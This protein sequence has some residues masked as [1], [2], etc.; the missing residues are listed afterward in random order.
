MKYM[1]SAYIFAC[2]FLFGI[3]SSQKIN[4]YSQIDSINQ[5]KRDSVAIDLDSL[6]NPNFEKLTT[7]F[8]D[9]IIVQNNIIL[10]S[11]P[12]DIPITPFNIIKNDEKNWFYFGQN[13]LVF[14]QA[15]FSNWISGGNNNIGVIGKVNYNL[16][17]KNRKH[18]LEN[19]IQLG[20]G[21]VATEGEET[22]KTEDYI[23]LM[24]N[25]GYELGSNYYLSAGFQFI[26][27]FT[28]GYNYAV[29][30]N[31]VYEDRVSKFMAP[32]YLNLGLGI[33]YN[34][35][36]NFQVIIRPLNGKFTFVLDPE[37]QK[38]GRFGLE[39]DGQSTR[40]EIGA[41]LNVIYRIK[42]HKG[43]NFDQQLG[44][45]SNYLFHSERV[46]LSYNGVVNIKFNKFISTIISF[47]MVYD[48]DQIQKLQRKQTLGVG[49][50]YNLG[51]KL[52]NQRPKKVI[53]PFIN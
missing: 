20:Y 41:M 15:S 42:L 12:E 34:P 43:I 52:D 26:S 40:A 7:R 13:N 53:K 22:K 18:Y 4:I 35:K 16:I 2:F 8:K 23:N 5:K 17:Y 49:L 48:H 36:E 44:L 21:L 3:F 33:S 50:S 45:F 25:Y 46:D 51:Q 37:L 47:D 14:N 6:S 9:T 11:M 38:I 24:T 30:P 39:R 1:R 31:P 10:P 19:I 32:G 29:T 27:Q 28:P